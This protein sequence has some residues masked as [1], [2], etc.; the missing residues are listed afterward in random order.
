MVQQKARFQ[1]PQRPRQVGFSIIELMLALAL[2]MLVVTGIVQ[3]FLT[4]TVAYNI[5]TGQARLQEN[6]RVSLDIITSIVR[7]SGYYGC[8]PEW[9]N[10]ANLLNSS[11]NDLIYPVD[12]WRPIQAFHGATGIPPLALPED[13]I[14]SRPGFRSEVAGVGADF[15]SVR[16]L[17]GRTARLAEVV[18]PDSDPVVATAA[19]GSVP[20]S[21]GDIVLLSDCD[22]AA[23]F[24]LTGI[25]VAGNEATL[26]RGSG[27][28]PMQ[29]ESADAS[30]SQPSA[31]T[32]RSY[33][34]DA[35]VGRVVTTSFFV[36]PS[37][38]E[39]EAGNT[40]NSLWMRQ[41]SQL[42]E[43]V[44]GVD[45]LRV[46]FGVNLNA[47]AGD[48]L[49]VEQYMTYQDMENNNIDFRRIVAVRITVTVNSVEAVTDDP[50][51]P[52]LRR[53][54]S[55]TVFLRNANLRT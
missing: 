3:L 15:F 51:D 6:G 4:N 10:I 39:N 1:P 52:M 31:G 13:S 17:S 40:V 36:G 23:M 37:T 29:N 47:S 27:V 21:A 16:H 12:I 7:N 11:N 42:S 5:Q 25:S 43:L 45:D 55:E 14:P 33:G 46:L 19:D 54:F 2:G 48:D 49:R 22:Q 44:L 8:G 32:V 34:R 41:G 24:H 9:A 53:T 20:F 30:L 35:V 28:D 18:Q 50:D 26:L 38:F